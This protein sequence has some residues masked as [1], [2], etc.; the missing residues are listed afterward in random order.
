MGNIRDDVG[1]GYSW[2]AHSSFI[3]YGCMTIENELVESQYVVLFFKKT[4]S[5]FSGCNVYD[6]CEVDTFYLN[7]SK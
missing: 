7:E 5:L 2:I 3:N 1:R 4:I 6:F